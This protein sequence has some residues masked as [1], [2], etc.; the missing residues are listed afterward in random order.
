[1]PES[2]NPLA[3]ATAVLIAI[4]TAFAGM[5]FRKK[6][7]SLLESDRIIEEAKRHGWIT[8]GRLV[9]SLFLRRDID[10]QW[11]A[12][13]KDHW[14]VE[15]E[16]RVGDQRYRYKRVMFEPPAESV[17]LY[18]DTN[19]PG[20]AVSEGEHIP[21]KSFHALWFLAVIVMVVLIRFVFPE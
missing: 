1:M 10:A 9:K 7:G 12:K 17:T 13:R 20:K 11:T 18:Y 14:A 5:A 19:H 3:A 16:Y 6:H 4:I 15:Y 2:I 8:E 21:G